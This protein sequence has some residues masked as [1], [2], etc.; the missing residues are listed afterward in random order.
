MLRLRSLVF[1]TGMVLSTIVFAVIS[2]VILPLRFPLR[3]RIMSGW[4]SFNLFLLRLVCGLKHEV[5]GKENIPPGPAIILCKHQS[6]WETLALQRLFP[7]QSWVLKR[8]LLWIPVYGWGLASLHPI[9]IDRSSGVRALRQIVR[10]GQKRLEEGLWVLIFPEGTR[11]L[12]GETPTYQAGGGLLAEKSGC[13]VVPVAHNA[14]YYWP[15]NSLDKKPG[16]IRLI[17]GPPI[18]PQGKTA[19]EITREAE[20]W[21]EETVAKLPVRSEA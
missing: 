5:E 1:Y 21:I 11:T 10:Q 2:L 3:F 6:A 12:P 13:P 4:S 14:G 9:S 8:E 18:Q 19:Q 16:T 20:R 17:I 15:R 7:P